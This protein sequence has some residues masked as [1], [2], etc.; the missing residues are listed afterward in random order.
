MAHPRSVALVTLASSYH[1]NRGEQKELGE[2]VW[3]G[4]RGKDSEKMQEG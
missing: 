2:V 1:G 3:S 4:W